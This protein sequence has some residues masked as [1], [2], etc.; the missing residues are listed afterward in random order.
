MYHAINSAASRK[1]GVEGLDMM[2]ARTIPVY[3]G[4]KR[5]RTYDLIA[6]I[7]SHGGQVVLNPSGETACSND[8]PSPEE[9]K[10][11]AMYRSLQRSDIRTV[12]PAIVWVDGEI[13]IDGTVGSASKVNIIFSTQP[14]DLSEVDFRLDRAPPN[15]A[16]KICREW[17]RLYAEASG[18]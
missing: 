8:V 6:R 5:L 13:C 9:I 1:T 4:E 12:V 10:L 3:Q 18:V 7:I 16:L 11:G 2:L 14:M 17:Q 15:M